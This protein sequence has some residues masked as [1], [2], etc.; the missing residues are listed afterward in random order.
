MNER[1]GHNQ[2]TLPIAAL[3]R[4]A[5]DGELDQHQED[6]LRAHL[7]DHPEDEA[8][9]GF[10]RDLRGACARAC[11]PGG[12][13]PAGLR[14]KILANCRDQA[15]ADG[16]EE[17]A[18]QTRDRSFWAGRV[19]VRF[20][21]VAAVVALVA[22]V[23]FMIGRGG[24]GLPSGPHQVSPEVMLARVVHFVGNE[25]D[26]CADLP[27]LDN[28]KFTVGA[29]DRLEP[30]FATLAGREVSLST[31]LTAEQQGLHFFDAG[32]CHL[33][34]GGTAMHI[35]FTTDDPQ[36][37]IVSV[38]AQVDGSLELDEGITY[39]GEYNGVMV[40]TWR[41]GEVRYVLACCTDQ[42]L[43]CG[44]EAL[45]CPDQTLPVGEV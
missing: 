37:G 29:P 31:V 13:A 27:E 12:A 39:T 7:A 34:S 30:E 14:D 20:G 44:I 10:E 4:M 42:G 9:I 16:I 1:E 28:S 2:H 21:A 36:A 15:V 3:L 33:P 8:R 26:R 23:S 22:A 43:G 18:S 25:H 38:W 32:R 17:R 11:S 41:V 45:D 35:R 19:V 5:A 24:P 6:R 40:R